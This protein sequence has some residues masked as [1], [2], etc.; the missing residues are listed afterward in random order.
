MPPFNPV[1]TARNEIL[2]KLSKIFKKGKAAALTQAQAI[3]GLGGIGKTQTAVKYVYDHRYDYDN[4]FWVTADTETS[5]I[6][7]YTDIARALN[8]PEKDTEKH[9]PEETAQAVKKQ[10][11]NNENNWLL[12]IDN[13]DDIQILQNF[14]P[15]NK[16]GHIIVTTRSTATGNIA[17]SIELTK[18]QPEEGALLLL[19]RAKK[20][21]N[22]ISLE[23]V[24]Q[25]LRDK[26]KDISKEMDGLPLA[27]DQAGAYIE[28]TKTPLED[29]L[30]IYKEEGIEILRDRGRFDVG[31]PDSVV[32][33]FSL[34]FKQIAKDPT[35]A[36]LIYL[37]SFL[38]PDAIPLDIFIKGDGELGENLQLIVNSR[39]KFNKTI[40]M[41]NRFSLI[42]LNMMSGV[43][44][45]HR[46]VQ[47]V[48]RHEMGNDKCQ[49]W[50]ERAVNVLNKAFPTND[51]AHWVE[52][53]KLLPHAILAVSWIDKWQFESS[54]TGFLLYKLASYCKSSARYV[55]TENLFK[56]SL[57]ILEK[58]LGQ[59]HPDTA[60]IVSDLAGLYHEQGKYSDAEASFN[61]ALYIYRKYL[62]PDHTN[63]AATLNNLSGLYYAMGKYEDAASMGEQ[64]LE[65]RVDTLGRNHPKIAAT[66]NNLAG[67]YQ[68]QGH[69]E[70]AENFY[71]EALSIN[72]QL[73]PTDHPD[74]ATTIH[75]LARL[76]E[77]QAKY[78]EAEYLF[79]RALALRKRIFGDKHP[80]V[81]ATL[82]CL[83]GNYYLCGNYSES[84][85]LYKQTLSIYEKLF[86]H[87][88]PEI[89]LTLHELAGVYKQRGEYTKA[90]KLLE[91]SL[92]IR[93]KILSV[94]HPDLLNTLKELASIY[95]LQQQFNKAEST[96]RR[97][98]AIQ[99]K[100][101]GK[102]HRDVANTLNNFAGI[103]L[104]QEKLIEAEPMFKQAL[105]IQ[106]KVLGSEHPEVAT[107]L[108]NLAGV[109]HYQHKYPEAESLCERALKIY[110]KAFGLE[111]PKIATTL[112]SL[113]WIYFLQGK[114]GKA[115][116]LFKKAISMTEK[117]L[118]SEHPNLAV[119][120][121]NYAHLLLST[122]RIDEALKLLEQSKRIQ[123]K[124][125]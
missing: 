68:A 80:E 64:A 122:K 54:Q 42:Q 89:A 105:F 25:E 57:L 70:K 17:E 73:L 26:A 29:Y 113:A 12:V 23:A 106:E 107:T 84:E 81:A 120:L 124:V 27:L 48:I 66:L 109:Y 86:P 117:L 18:M 31:H 101:L 76:Y 11:E 96:F 69:N 40:E 99:E 95:N 104:T 21:S 71:K 65:L 43:I 83:A 97:V 111:H 53:E 123:A 5:L 6:L 67:I 77:F 90:Q 115:E 50:A 14:L 85:T 119:Y 100:V 116:P 98:L 33:T 37:C 30:D 16:T 72:E 20:F 56:H 59:E 82:S 10:L 35:V 39:H 46:L 34:A 125:N 49:L 32:I 75:N 13:A 87:E 60:A 118:G 51:Y 88:H 7:G 58:A 62:S 36:D 108:S 4:I 3:N 38:A 41:A 74:L 121:K 1:F 45:I 52:C 47:E 22:D 114:F 78:K 9:K 91:Q 8:L 112:N 44:D 19:R 93:E 24:P 2:E 55:G 94:E 28:E 102:E 61:R 92:S 79:K 63:I 110:N 103:Y 15:F